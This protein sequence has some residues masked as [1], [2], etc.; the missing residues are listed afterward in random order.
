MKK[1]RA[2]AIVI[3]LKTYRCS[4]AIAGLVNVNCCWFAKNAL[5]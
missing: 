4:K 5:T 2:K 1:T 3:A